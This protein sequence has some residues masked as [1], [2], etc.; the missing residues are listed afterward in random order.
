MTNRREDAGAR[1]LLTKLD[2]VRPQEV[3][4]LSGAGVSVEGPSSLPTGWELT[5]R[6]FDAFFLPGTLDTVLAHHRSVGWLTRPH[7]QLATQTVN[8]R[9]PRLETVLG[10][11]ARSHGEHMVDQA[12]ADVARAVPNRLHHFFAQHLSHNGGHLTANFDECVESAARIRDLTFADTELL[13]FHGSTGPDGG[14]LGAT[15]E[16]IERGFPPD[17]AAEFVRLL[18]K[19]PVLLVLGY[20]GSD[21]FDVDVTFASLGS[22]ALAGRSVIWVIHSDHEPHLLLDKNED[23]E[24]LP[25]LISTLRAFG[26]QVDIFCGPTAHVLR[27]LA[28]AWGFDPLGVP[29]PR[30]HQPPSLVVDNDMKPVATLA[31]Y[32]EIGLFDQIPTLMNPPPQRA[33]GSLVRSVTSATLWEQGRWNDLRRWWVAAHTESTGERASRFERIGACLWVQG[34]LVPAYLWLTWHRRR[35]DGEAAI[36]L[37]ETEGRVIE[38]MMR[39]PELRW[40]AR[41]AAGQMINLFGT[42]DQRS[43]VHLFRRRSDLATS[44]TSALGS[45]SG[46]RTQHAETSSEWF[47]QAGSVL[48]WISYR[49]RHLRDTYS[50]KI[51]DDELSRRYRE[52]QALY[53]SVGSRAGVI[54]THLL[55]GA[56]RVFSTFEVLAGVFALQYGWWQRVRIIA[57][58]V[59]LRLRRRIDRMHPSR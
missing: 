5:R 9:I 14:Q 56:H 42:A 11:V 44:L 13:H 48:A 39:A 20:S 10:V 55:P 23:A 27:H 52:I 37:A 12:V 15:L 22:D 25:Q 32:L 43:G 41:R 30:D 17:V 35:N 53:R 6:V 40:F 2:L 1:Q 57:R 59:V 31:L 29:E 45:D 51:P 54:R 34:R 18:R 7:C 28:F 47:G 4:V 16:R 8:P 38:H 33:P 3:T 19:R 24:P 46:G 50:T 21:F 26:A 49:H 58:H 36:M